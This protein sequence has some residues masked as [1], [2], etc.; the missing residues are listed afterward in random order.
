MAAPPPLT[1]EQE[2]VLLEK[3]KTWAKEANVGDDVCQNVKCRCVECTCGAGC[4]CNVSPAVVCDPCKDFK[5]MMMA[6]ATAARLESAETWYKDKISSTYPSLP[7]IQASELMDLRRADASGIVFVDVRP[8]AERLISMIPG[9]VAQ[10]DF[11]ADPAK[12]SEGKLVVPY[13]TLGLASAAVANELLK[14][15][16]R[17]WAEVRNFE[18]SLVGWCH[19]GG[20]LLDSSGAPTMRVHGVRSDVAALFPVSN[21]EVI[22]ESA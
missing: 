14:S 13:C 19:Q 11:Q 1:A 3:K 10:A 8:E 9:S 22:L 2:Q 5:T 12:Y 17:P 16:K 15:E 21:Y 6:K 20:E 4:T 7:S 18:L